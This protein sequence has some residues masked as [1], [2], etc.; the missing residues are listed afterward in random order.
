M[1]EPHKNDTE[2][3]R[4][5]ERLLSENQRLSEQVKRLILTES[6]LYLL[7]DVLD[8]QVRV[9]RHLYESG[10]KLNA[11]FDE[12]EVLRLTT[13]FVISALNFQRCA[14]FTRA[15][16]QAPFRVRMLDGY[17]DEDEKTAVARL[18]LPA[19][20]TVLSP[21]FAGS[22]YL[23][24]PAEGEDPSLRALGLRLLMNE[25]CCSRWGRTH[26]GR[27]GWW[28]REAGR[29]VPSTTRAS[30]PTASSSS[31]SPTWSPRPRPRSTT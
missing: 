11:T 8:A 13:D 23:M 19:T 15:D 4:R 17:Y 27:S 24:C 28:R 7:Q 29:A 30:R 16:E 9:Y 3:E 14:L 5:L 18:E 26:G 12:E 21:L 6:R 31:A 10:K 20:D 22:E 2:R 25:S 1:D